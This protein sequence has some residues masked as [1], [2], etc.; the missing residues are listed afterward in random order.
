MS[1]LFGARGRSRGCCRGSEDYVDMGS[2]VS[3]NQHQHHKQS[4]SKLE[5]QVIW[6]TFI[7]TRV[8]QV[9]SIVDLVPILDLSLWP[10]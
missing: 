8:I 7:V 6:T 1:G 2:T 4:T 9:I 10:T 3:T 5:Q